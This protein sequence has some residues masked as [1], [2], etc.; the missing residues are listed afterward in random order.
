VAGGRSEWERRQAALRREA[1]RQARE[2]AKVA[3]EQERERQR[4]HLERQQSTAERKTAKVAQR[5]E[6]L[7]HILLAALG[8]RPL[9]FDQMRVA[10]SIRPF[11][12]EP[13]LTVSEPAPDWA[14]YQPSPPSGLG[15]LFWGKDR[16]ERALVEA[17]ARYNSAT[18]SY[19]QR[20]QQRLA[21]LNAARSAYD[22]QVA[23][24]QKKVA[25]ANARLNQI[26]TDFDAGRPEALEWFTSKA[27]E[28]STYPTGFPKLFQVAYRPE[29][30]DLVVEV[31][32]Q[33]RRFVPTCSV[34]RPSAPSSKISSWPTSI[35]RLV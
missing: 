15:K 20:V 1:E 28:R 22:R 3:K 24:E 31:E 11:E 6:K 23:E 4:Q 25:E 13:R 33:V 9:S 12:P 29:N 16:Y 32:R 35:P 2:A 8:M 27:L 10:G 18:D 5:I 26:R 19:Q 17:R 30:R 14:A 21:E 34:W 7:D